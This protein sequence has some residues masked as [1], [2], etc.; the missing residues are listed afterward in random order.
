ME[1]ILKYIKGDRAI[2]LIMLLLSVFSLLLVY[3]SIVTLAYRHHDGNTL[4]Y[5][6]RHGFI[7]VCGLGL[8][9]LAHKVKF[10]YYSKIAQLALYVSIP[11]LLITLLMGTSIN[12]ANRWLTI[13]VI[14]QTF[15]TSDLAKVALIMFVARFLAIRQDEIRDFKRGFLPLLVPIFIVC[16]LILPADLSTAALLFVNCLV[17]MF[18]GRVQL[19]HIGLLIV[20]GAIAL[21]MVYMTGKAMPGTFS[22]L[23]TWVSRVETFV[24]P[25][26]ANINQNYQS[27]QSKIAIATGGVIG[28]MPGKSTQRNFLPHPYSDF[29]YSIVLE[30]YGLIGGFVTLMLYLMLLFRSIKI[31]MNCSRTFG[32]LLAIGIGFSLVFQ[33][34]VNMA[35][36][37]NLVPV[38]GQPLPM[39]SMGGTSIWFTCFAV[40][41][42]LS[43]SAGVDSSSSRSM[44]RP[45]AHAA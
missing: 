5:L 39:V 14:N 42:I 19:K 20:S 45:L 21:T 17:L 28:K 10:T 4:Y 33:A 18:I 9:F 43:V 30:E 31:G 3:S 1:A 38:T 26:A 24:S 12:S 41:I 6:F 36:A 35:V 23:D 2:W 25:D 16:G 32:S 44:N 13:P 34:M 37:V 27:D 22:R 29:I 7:L 11:L 8:M 15:Q 40:G